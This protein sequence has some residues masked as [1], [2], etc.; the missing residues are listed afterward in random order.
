[1]KRFHA[2]LPAV[3][4]NKDENHDKRMP[5]TRPLKV[6]FSKG[7]RIAMV[8]QC[9]P[10]L[11]TVLNVL[12]FHLQEKRAEMAKEMAKCVRYKEFS[13]IHFTITGARKINRYNE[14]FVI[15]RFV[16]STFHYS[17]QGWANMP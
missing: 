11:V 9:L 10:T 16:K 17:A 12:S 13:S 3:A 8:L 14:D 15:Y 1:M 6:Y 4:Y 2:A 7:F 5:S